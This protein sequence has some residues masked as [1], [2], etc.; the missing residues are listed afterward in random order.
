MKLVCHWGAGDKGAALETEKA[1]ASRVAAL[2]AGVWDFSGLINVFS[3]SPSF[4]TG[5]SSW[6]ALFTAV[7]NGDSAGATAAL[8]QLEPILQH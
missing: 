8:H 1:L 5:R 6:V 4:T 3:K 2:Q 7:Q